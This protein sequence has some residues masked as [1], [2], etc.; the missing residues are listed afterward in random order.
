ML[1]FDSV[2]RFA[3]A[4]REI[5]LAIG[6]PP[7]NRGF[8]PSVFAQLPKLL[9]RAGTS[10]TGTITGF[11]TILVEGDDLDEPVS[12]A[13]R[14]VLDGHIVLARVLANRNHYPAIDVLNSI[15]RLAP[16][17]NRP[18]VERAS[19]VVKRL[20]AVYAEAEDLINVGAYVKGS[21]PEIDRAIDKMP[22]I[23]EFLMQGITEKTEIRETIRR[24]GEIAEVPIPEEE[25][26]SAEVGI[27]SSD[28]ESGSNAE[29]D[30]NSDLSEMD[31]TSA[32]ADSEAGNAGEDS[33][34]EADEILPAEDEASR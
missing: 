27:E 11:Y 18:E 9:E 17:I 14:G 8:T 21:S 31:E 32:V 20:L 16:H 10:A 26:K 15:S 2:T 28:K 12:D 23:N 7:A 6:E 25:P 13:V 19:G 3:R 33:S 1:L 22:S 30:M 29:S 4:S 5:G 24:L 34:R